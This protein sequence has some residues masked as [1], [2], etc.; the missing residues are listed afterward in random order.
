MINNEGTFRPLV[1]FLLGRFFPQELVQMIINLCFYDKVGIQ[2]TKG[3]VQWYWRMFPGMQARYL[4]THTYGGFRSTIVS[5]SFGNKQFVVLDPN[6]DLEEI[7]CSGL[8]KR[9]SDVGFRYA[10]ISMAQNEI[11]VVN[12]D[13]FEPFSYLESTGWCT[14]LAGVSPDGSG[15][16]LYC[17]LGTIELVEEPG[18]CYSAYSD[19][20]RDVPGI[21]HNYKCGGDV[22]QCDH[23][24]IWTEEEWSMYGTIRFLDRIETVY[25]IEHRIV[26][27]EF[28]EH[29]IEEVVLGNCHRCHEEERLV[30]EWQ[31]W[32]NELGEEGELFD[33]MW[34]DDFEDMDHD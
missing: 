21:T 1:E 33:N 23:V 32:M 17:K 16:P 31:D 25:D 7:Q 3:L 4:G 24:F 13:D 5:L 29:Y 11:R 8:Y 2:I 27:Y 34:D 20:C 22:E 19:G 6:F 28:G 30:L 12:G 9:V 26:E 15:L 14:C 18:V 10:N